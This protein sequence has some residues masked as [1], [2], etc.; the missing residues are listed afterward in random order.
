M[1]IAVD[2]GGLRMRMILIAC[3]EVAGR[4]D[5]MLKSPDFL[6]GKELAIILFNWKSRWLKQEDLLLLMKSLLTGLEQ[7]LLRL[8]LDWMLDKVRLF[9]LR[10]IILMLKA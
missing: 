5:M 8:K 10:E 2:W 9:Q 7:E 3:K 6:L 1:D 4:E